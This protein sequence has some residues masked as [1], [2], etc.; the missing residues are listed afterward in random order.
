MRRTF[1]CWA[2]RGE[3]T[4]MFGRASLIIWALFRSK[5]AS[6]WTVPNTH[7]T[8]CLGRTPEHWCFQRQ[9]I[10][11]DRGPWRSPGSD[12][13]VRPP[14][15]SHLHIRQ[16]RSARED[17]SR[18]RKSPLFAGIKQVHWEKKPGINTAAQFGAAQSTQ[19]LFIMH[20]SVAGIT[21]D[22]A[23]LWLFLSSNA[24]RNRFGHYSRCF[25]VKPK[26]S[27]LTCLDLLHV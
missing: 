11:R 7:V 23:L 20:A 26:A 14:A 12:E 13:P 19:S 4:F 15:R 3:Q 21:E 22:N 1:K 18:G 5:P 2:T 6:P 9:W 10:R 8:V 16:Q 24:C 27:A 17:R 25:S